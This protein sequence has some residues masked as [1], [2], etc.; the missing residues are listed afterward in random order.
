[1]AK[2][3]L[4]SDKYKGSGM[5]KNKGGNPLFS[6]TGDSTGG[7]NQHPNSTQ[8]ISASKSRGRVAG[9]GSGHGGSKSSNPLFMPS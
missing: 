3:G 2:S 7:K 4:G 5:K 1:M 8:N 6:S 9:P